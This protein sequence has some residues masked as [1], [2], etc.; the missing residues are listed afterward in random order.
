MRNHHVVPFT[1]NPLSCLLQ[2]H[3]PYP[4]LPVDTAPNPRIETEGLLKASCTSSNERRHKMTKAWRNSY[5]EDLRDLERCVHRALTDI[6]SPSETQEISSLLKL[7]ETGPQKPYQ[8]KNAA[9][10]LHIETHLESLLEEATGI[11]Q[12]L[13]RV[14]QFKSRWNLEL[15]QGGYERKILGQWTDTP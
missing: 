11:Q 5:D 9:Y 4:A 14:E 3:M 1:V 10:L 6:A 15:T 13:A 8:E 2:S 7:L 12:I